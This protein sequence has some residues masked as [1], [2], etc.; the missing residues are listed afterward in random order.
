MKHPLVRLRDELGWAHM[1][2]SFGAVYNNGA[3][4]P[5]SRTRLMVGNSIGSVLVVQR[6]SQNSAEISIVDDPGDEMGTDRRFQALPA[7]GDD[8]T[9][10]V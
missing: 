5:R 9:Q 2:R 3:G 1:R 6:T 8:V 4:Q 7:L 10:L